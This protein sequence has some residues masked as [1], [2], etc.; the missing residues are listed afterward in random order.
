LS[1]QDS[2]FNLHA[3]ISGMGCALGYILGAIDWKH[4]VLNVIGL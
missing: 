3:F 4:T 1:D 2:S